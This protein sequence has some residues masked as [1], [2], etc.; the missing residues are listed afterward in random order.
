[1]KELNGNDPRPLHIRSLDA[2]N[3][4]AA[5][6]GRDAMERDVMTEQI[7]STEIPATA[8]PYCDYASDSAADLEGQE[9]P[10][11]EDFSICISCAQILI[12]ADDLTLRKPTADEEKSAR[13]ITDV[14]RYQAA[15]RAHNRTTLKATASK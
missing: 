7:H 2:G 10:S 5:M 14:R 12:F 8:C 1:M 3:I 9:T 15:V 11:P 13:Q 6:A 4:R